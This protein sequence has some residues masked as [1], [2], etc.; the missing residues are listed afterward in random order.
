MSC[1]GK[2]NTWYAGPMVRKS[3]THLNSVKKASMS[4]SDY[5]VLLV[6]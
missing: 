5:E 3:I 2:G 1:S 6:S 4:E